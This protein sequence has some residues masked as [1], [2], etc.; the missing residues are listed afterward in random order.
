MNLH[1]ASCRLPEPRREHGCYTL[2]GTLHFF[3]TTILGNNAVVAL[4]KGKAMGKTFAQ[5]VLER[6]SEKSVF[7]GDT[8]LAEPDLVLP[9]NSRSGIIGKLESAL[10]GGII[11][12]PDRIAF[13]LENVIQGVA[14]GDAVSLSEICGFLRKNKIE[15][16]YDIGCGTCHQVISENHHALPGTIMAGSYRDISTYGAF[17]AF[18]AEIS[19]AE[20][21]DLLVTGRIGIRVPET[22]D[23]NL[24]GILPERVAAVDLA[25]TILGEIGSVRLKGKTLEFHGASV[26]TLLIHQRMTIA[27]MCSQGELAVFPA[28]IIT[29][30]YFFSTDY[31][32]GALWSDFDA[33]FCNT[34]EFS[35]DE[36]VPVVSKLSLEDNVCPVL[37]L[38]KTSVDQV[39]LGGLTSGRVEDLRAALK[40]MKERSV[41]PA[42]RM[43]VEPASRNEYMKALQEGLIEQF[44]NA[45]AVVLPPGCGLC[46]ELVNGILA[47]GEVCLSTAD[48]NPME[49]SGDKEAF[50]YLG[51]PETAAASAVTGF[52]TDPRE[53]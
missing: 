29:Q 28:D 2:E 3:H 13:V 42:V 14:G 8:V 48:I 12:Y 32:S 4:R 16:L 39:Y 10:H 51:S 38:P 23:V 5:K 22:I 24:S 21:A 43:F 31:C 46:T 44:V 33:D 53:V 30:N 20:T 27:S 50:I 7:P 41:V 19:S 35:M 11:K 36:I 47:P 6:A 18:T 15:K 26:S 34:L 45:G 1:K 9:W 25:L 40:V 49:E 17:N 37:E 52:I